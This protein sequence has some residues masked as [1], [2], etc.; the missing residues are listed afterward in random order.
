MNS[1]EG[2]KADLVTYNRIAALE[3]KIKELEAGGGGSP[4][5]P[6]PDEVLKAV[7]NQAAIATVNEPHAS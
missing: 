5:A 2:L 3:T 4:D 7:Q 6:L 1:D